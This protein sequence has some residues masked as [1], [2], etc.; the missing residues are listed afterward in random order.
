MCRE[1]RGGRA[2][3]RRVRGRNRRRRRTLRAAGQRRT[4]PRAARKAG[5]R[6]SVP[7][8]AAR[9]HCGRE[10]AAAPACP[11]HRSGGRG[12][13]GKAASGW[14]WPRARKSVVKGKRVSVSVE[15][16]GRRIMKKKKNKR[17]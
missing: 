9:F 12:A 4:D 1:C 15:L 2:A 8:P 16:G 14:P 6:L 17:R 7:P 3:R 11:R 10:C 13:E 5:V